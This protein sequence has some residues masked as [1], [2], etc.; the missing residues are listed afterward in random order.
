MGMSSIV[1][2]TSLPEVVADATA[3]AAGR[4]ADPDGK[5][6][7]RSEG[8]AGDVTRGCGCGAGAIGFVGASADLHPAADIMIDAHV[9]R[10]EERNTAAQSTNF[11][12]NP[13]A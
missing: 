10:M 9:R 2:I 12:G 13:F 6:P 5:T 8:V 11:T 3:G 1:A 4:V 7:V